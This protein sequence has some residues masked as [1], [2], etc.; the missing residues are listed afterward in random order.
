M[1]SPEPQQPGRYRKGKG[2]ELLDDFIMFPWAEAAGDGGGGVCV[3]TDA[4]HSS[5][6]TLLVLSPWPANL[7]E[8]GPYPQGLPC[9]RGQVVSA[10]LGQRG[11]SQHQSD[12]SPMVPS[13]EVPSTTADFPKLW[14]ALPLLLWVQVSPPDEGFRTGVQ[15]RAEPS[16]CSQPLHP[17]SCSRTRAGVRPVGGYGA[18]QRGPAL[19]PTR[20]NRSAHTQENP[21]AQGGYSPPSDPI[22]AHPLCVEGW[23]VRSVMWL[24]ARETLFGS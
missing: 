4:C 14:P 21:V 15:H 17:T 7:S 22:S 19:S 2:R 3:N 6:P 11:T 1:S 16:S 18:M 24:W 13:P 9:R 8:T 23:R 5:T 20:P 10:W 12:V